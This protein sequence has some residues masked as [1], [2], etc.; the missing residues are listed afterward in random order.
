MT[1]EEWYR[2]RVL[3]SIEVLTEY[4]DIVRDGVVET[5]MSD[6]E[7]DSLYHGLC[8]LTFDINREI[9]TRFNEGS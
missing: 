9:N 2:H 3:D 1:R 4:L 6:D 7:F 8:M 5:S